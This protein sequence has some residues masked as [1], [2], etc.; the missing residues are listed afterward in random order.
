MIISYIN[1]IGVVSLVL[2]FIICSIVSCCCI[3]K[4]N[5][6]KNKILIVN[7]PFELDG[8]NEMPTTR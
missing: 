4:K 7:K 2:I 6:I 3:R 5:K 1:K 8:D